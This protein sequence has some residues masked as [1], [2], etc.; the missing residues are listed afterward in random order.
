MHSYRLAFNLL[1]FFQRLI[2]RKALSKTWSH[3][4]ALGKK[5]TKNMKIATREEFT[6]LRQWKG[7]KKICNFIEPPVYWR[8]PVLSRVSLSRVSHTSTICINDN[9]LFLSRQYQLLSD[10][11]YISLASPLIRGCSFSCQ[12]DVEIMTRQGWRIG[13]R[14]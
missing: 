3:S 1:R 8:V 5:F 7:Y 13:Y 6:S 2:W 10:N 12:S 9:A 14:D 11:F 4:N